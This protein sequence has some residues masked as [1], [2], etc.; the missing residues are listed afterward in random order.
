MFAIIFDVQNVEWYIICEAIES[1]CDMRNN[2][3]NMQ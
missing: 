2:I 3:H 1:A